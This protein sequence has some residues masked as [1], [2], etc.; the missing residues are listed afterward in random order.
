MKTVTRSPK[1]NAR[2]L[3]MPLMPTKISRTRMLQARMETKPKLPKL[4]KQ[5]RNR[6]R[7]SRKTRIKRLMTK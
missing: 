1:R 4:S 3:K 5:K 6:R 7:K 2:R